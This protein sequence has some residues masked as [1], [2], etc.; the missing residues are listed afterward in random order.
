MKRPCDIVVSWWRSGTSGCPK[1][2]GKTKKPVKQEKLVDAYPQYVRQY[3][4]FE[5]N[6]ADGLDPNEL[7]LESNWKAWFRCPKDS[8]SWHRLNSR[9]YKAAVVTEMRDAECAMEQLIAS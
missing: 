7:P 9:D 3:W 8:H 1:C 6:E 2:A 4:D 5:K